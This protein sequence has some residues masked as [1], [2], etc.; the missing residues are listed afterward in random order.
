MTNIDPAEISYNPPRFWWTK[1][2]AIA[3]ACLVAI[4]VGSW[5]GVTF[6]GQYQLDSLIASYRAA[7]EPVYADDFNIHKNIPDGE[8]AATYYNKASDA[9]IWPAA[10]GF[11]ITESDLIESIFAKDG[12]ARTSEI[13]YVINSNGAAIELLKRAAQCSDAEWRL[14]FAKPMIDTPYSDVSAM[15]RLGKLL[16]LAVMDSHRKGDDRQAVDLLFAQLRLAR[17]RAAIR[18]SLLD[19]MVATSIG[20]LSCDVIQNIGPT[21]D[22]RDADGMPVGASA[23]KSGVEEIISE[24][25]DERVY[26]DSFSH[27]L[28]S[29][30]AVFI[31]TLEFLQTGE[32]LNWL[33]PGVSKPYAWAIRPLLVTDSRRIANH[34][35]HI[36]GACKLATYPA[37]MSE[38]PNPPIVVVGRGLGDLLYDGIS[39]AAYEGFIAVEMARLSRRRMA[40]TSLAIRLFEVDHGRRPV[41]LD[42]LIPDYLES[43]PRDPF[44]SGNAS[45][46]YLPT[47]NPPVL[48]SIGRDGVDDG[49]RFELMGIEAVDWEKFDLVFYLDGDRPRREP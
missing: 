3:S 16:S 19:H 35:T 45:I 14:T 42:E 32:S 23:S 31:D 47:A 44:A 40:A 7:G 46:Q 12:R 11:E 49:S 21:L 41:K 43:I 39:N 24:L 33:F 22:V 1:R 13:E 27:A 34:M 28:V 8:N 30:R 6:I 37:I 10:F 36:A 25:L 26:A 2:I 5:G 18:R 17:H 48:Y 4:V 9:Y 20:E 15:R 38:Y 29:E